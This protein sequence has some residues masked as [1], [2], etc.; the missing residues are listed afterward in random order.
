MI[1]RVA[2]ASSLVALLMTGMLGGGAEAQSDP[3]QIPCTSL[4]ITSMDVEEL[5][6]SGDAACDLTGTLAA[7]PDGRSMTIPD[8]GVQVVASAATIEGSAP[9]PDIVLENFESSGVVALEVNPDRG[10]DEAVTAWGPDA[11]VQEATEDLVTHTGTTS[12]GYTCTD[13]LWSQSGST[14]SKTYSWSYNA[15]VSPANLLPGVQRGG[16]VLTATVNNCGFVSA[17][18]GLKS[19]YAGTTSAGANI[20][21]NGTCA[22]SDGK[23]TQNFGALPSNILGVA[24]RWSGSA[25]EADIAYNSTKWWHAGQGACPASHYRLNAIAAHEFGHVFGLGHAPNTQNVMRTSFST[26]AP[27]ARVGFG[28]FSGLDYLY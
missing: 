18:V 6:A 28:D 9:V 17:R 21:G 25:N 11:L 23:N 16:T 12:S 27:D 24:C 20:N 10:P 1:R 7:F 22:A 15:T 26:C 2:V 14:R 3:A 4:G 8:P 5:R 13:G 19:P